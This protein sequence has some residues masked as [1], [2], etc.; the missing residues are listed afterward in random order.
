MRGFF[1]SFIYRMKS[2]A[3][4]LCLFLGLISYAQV[5][6][7]TWIQLQ[8]DMENAV[9]R[10]E[11]INTKLAAAEHLLNSNLSEAEMYLEEAGNL[12]L[13]RDFHFNGLL[14]EHYATLY[15]KKGNYSPAA[16]FGLKA[17]TFFEKIPDTL[18]IVRSL[19]GLGITGRY[20]SDN[21]QSIKYFKKAAFLSGIKKDT[22]LISQ[23][24]NMMGIAYRRL[25]KP[26]SAMLSYQEAI[27]WVEG[28][29]Y[30]G[31]MAS[32]KNN[33][34]VLYST[35][36]RYDKS[37]PLLL[38]NLEYNKKAK[39]NMN[40]AIGYYNIA[41]DYY[42]L[43]DYAKSEQ[44][45]DSSFNM[46]KALGYQFRVAKAAQL[47]SDIGLKT[48]NY[49]KAYQYH[50]LFHAISDSIYNIESEKKLKEFM[51]TREFDLEKR[52]MELV[53]ASER[54]KIRS[55]IFILVSILI[56]GIFIAYLW[57]RNYKG[58]IKYVA[59][60]LEKQR[61]E[62]ELLNE[63]IKVSEAELKWLV[64]DNKMRLD[65]LKEFYERLKEDYGHHVSK[66]S[67]VYIRSLMLAVQ[68]QIGTE[69]KLSALQNKIEEVNL[70]F[71]S[72]LM[73]QYP[74]LTKA[75]RE[76]CALLRINLSM[77]EVA[78]IRNT[79][80]ESVKSIRYRLRKKMEIPKN[81][82]LEAHIQSL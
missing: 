5:S 66:E 6:D 70:G 69:D 13:D 80:V 64:A 56:L 4:T 61:L 78:S 51:L 36:K 46:S 62:K 50:K 28:T 63:K 40:T 79:T 59:T 29:Q 7:S 10:S 35:Q 42:W 53:A 12:I 15:R 77:K 43:K 9:T 34:A 20:R 47:K 73:D 32:I 65:Y 23:S 1:I 45:M 33:M 41:K 75:E 52:E 54:A 30:L 81:T 16:E 39:V 74:S 48:G 2:I 19:I 72:K 60:K 76:V 58:K 24:Y 8:V 31:R 68:Q 14:N 17:K 82:E 44:Y 21:E 55:Y 3:I 38:S 71:D 11:K 26:D 67:R 57:I 25:S 18:G 49:Q 27:K 37:L 22:F